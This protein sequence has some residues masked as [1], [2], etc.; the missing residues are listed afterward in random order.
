M[1]AF[2][3]Q[4]LKFA[5]CTLKYLPLVS[6]YSIITQLVFSGKTYDNTILKAQISTK[7]YYDF[8][9]ITV[10]YF[11]L[12]TTVLNSSLTQKN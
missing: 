12:R 11:L 9:T 3:F 10:Q 7:P 4:I 8:S 1:K 2:E 5:A 6:R